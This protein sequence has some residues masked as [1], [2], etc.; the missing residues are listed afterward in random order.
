MVARHGDNQIPMEKD[1]GLAELIV[2]EMG[3]M[4]VYKE[5][6]DLD[7]PEHSKSM[8]SLEL[9]HIARKKVI[10]ELATPCS[11]ETSLSQQF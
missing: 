3:S 11:G 9:W 8:S 10:Q 4:I 2:Q 6:Y 1:M 7:Y 5:A